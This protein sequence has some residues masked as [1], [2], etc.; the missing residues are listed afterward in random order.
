MTFA[1][2]TAYWTMLYIAL[3][4]EQPFGE[5]LNDLPVKDMQ[6]EMNQHLILLLNKRVQLPPRYTYTRSA[7]RLHIRKAYSSHDSSKFSNSEGEDDEFS[8][9]GHASEMEWSPNDLNKQHDFLDP[10]NGGRSLEE[11]ILLMH[12]VA[13]DDTGDKLVSDHLGIE[14]A[15]DIMAAPARAPFASHMHMSNGQDCLLHR[16]PAEL[17]NIGTRCNG[18]VAWYCNGRS[19]QY[20]VADTCAPTRPR[21]PLLLPEQPPPVF[22]AAPLPDID[23]VSAII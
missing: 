14:H 12:H 9:E 1:I 2:V 7:S 6:R 5:D 15:G 8:D 19:E 13:P 21:L 20:G 17:G 10:R 16:L 22:E 23:D 4:L 3:E 11:L 18:S